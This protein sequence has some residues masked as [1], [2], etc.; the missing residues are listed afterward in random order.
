MPNLPGT[1]RW[2]AQKVR[3]R[4]TQGRAAR[5]TA[6]VGNGLFFN[7]FV[8]VILAFIVP[9]GRHKNLG[10]CDMSFLILESDKLCQNINRQVK[11]HISSVS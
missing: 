1:P 6:R 5:K 7:I 8:K 4:P 9:I 3:T 2:D 11:C 10:L